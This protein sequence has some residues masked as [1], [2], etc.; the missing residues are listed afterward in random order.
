MTDRMEA[1]IRAIR[2]RT[3]QKRV[4]ME[5]RTN[6]ILMVC[7]LF[8]VVGIW[9]IMNQANVGGVVTV[10]GYYSTVLIR[11]GVSAYVV[12]AI[13]SFVAGV[14][15]TLLCIRWKK[16]RKKDSERT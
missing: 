11:S 9:Q 3:Q 12:T 5:R 1:R 13:V 15:V 6:T 7:S 14:A 2:K 4:Q 8:L 10:S 16:R